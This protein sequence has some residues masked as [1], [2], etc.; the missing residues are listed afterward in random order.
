MLKSEDRQIYIACG[1]IA[2][3]RKSDNVSTLIV[4]CVWTYVKWHCKALS[5][6]KAC[7]Y[8]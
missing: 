1:M 6:I 8:L 2:Y 4:K 3:G 7:Y 5:V